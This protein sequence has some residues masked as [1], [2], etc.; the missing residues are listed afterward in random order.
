MSSTLFLFLFSSP[1][2]WEG[3]E[4]TNNSGAEPPAR[5]NHNKTAWI[6]SV[7]KKSLLCKYMKKGKG[8]KYK[9]KYSKEDKEET[10]W[11]AE[12]LVYYKS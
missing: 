7:S 4:W 2:Q 1:S 11:K 3:G 10:S 12:S 8:I 9:Q 5:L 6:L